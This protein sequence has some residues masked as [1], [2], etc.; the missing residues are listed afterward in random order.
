MQ[1]GD[2]GSL[3]AARILSILESRTGAIWI[4][5]LGGGVNVLDPATRS[6]RQ[7]PFGSGAAGA[8]SASDVTAIVEDAHGNVWLGTDGG[9]LNLARADGTVLHVFRND[10]GNPATLPANTVYGLAVDAD[11]RVW[12]ATT[13]RARARRRS[14]G[15]AGGD[16]ISSPVERRRALERHAVR[17]GAGC[18]GP[19]LAQ[20]Q[21]RAHAPRPRDA[22][23]SRPIIAST[24]CRARSSR[25]APTF[26]CATGAWPSADRAASTSSIRPR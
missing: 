8:V 11:G 22:G 1:P 2:A 7:L 5:T 20:R 21:R 3:S 9:G 23:R 25:S 14:R 6:V 10:P 18:E 4:G 15:G 13:R 24:A 17:R 12:V 19:S 16:R 26:A